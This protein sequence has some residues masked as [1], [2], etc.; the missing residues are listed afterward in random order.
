MKCAS[1]NCNSVLR[2][3][4]TRIGRMK[5]QR[6]TKKS[7]EQN[8]YYRRWQIRCA[9]VSLAAVIYMPGAD[10]FLPPARQTL[11]KEEEQLSF[12]SSSTPP[13]PVYGV[14]HSRLN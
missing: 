1:Q 13:Y 8:R 6:G 5:L 3:A 10:P 12:R 9:A 11:P 4:L 14:V 7:R 2:P